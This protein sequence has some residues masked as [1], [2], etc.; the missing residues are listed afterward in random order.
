M[1][2]RPISRAV[3]SQA[4]QIEFAGLS[5]DWNPMHMDPVAARRTPAG[6][7]VVHGMHTVLRAVDD[8]A[9][10]SP[11]LSLPSTLT[12]RFPAPVYLNEVVEVL[13]VEHT[14]NSVR[15]Q[16]QVDGTAMV[17]LRMTLSHA[18]GSHEVSDPHTVDAAAVCRDLQLAE[19]ARRSGT[20]DLAS[21]PD[22][23]SRHFGNA[24]RWLGVDRVG[25][26]LCL[27]RLIGMECPGLHSLFSGFKIDFPLT[28]TPP[29][30]HYQVASIKDQL[31]L[32]KI[33]V[34]GFGICGTAEAFARQPPVVQPT[35]SEIMA[36]VNPTEFDLQRALIVGGSRGLGELTAKILAAGGGYPTITYAVGK[37]E[38]ER[39]V[40]EI[41]LAGGSC[42]ALHYDARLPPSLQLEQLSA[43]VS[44]LYYYATP[45]IQRRRTKR[46]DS[47]M[48]D[49][50]LE[51][52]VRG[53]YE[54]CVALREKSPERIAAFYPSSIAV[55]DRPREM[56]EYAMAKAAAEV[57]CADLN[58]SWPRVHI[59]SVRLPRVLTDQTAT[60]VPVESANALD[61]ILPIIRKVQAIEF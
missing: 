30:L 52:Y 19:M 13:E 49:D 27:S 9:A 14:N 31:R 12:V 33:E 24:V 20:I 55:E 44:R 34:R 47:A 39:V 61:V 3:F 37:D 8:F 1:T 5:G 25:G 23:I 18:R 60:V 53:F 51:F 21:E 22:R 10:S 54:L 6:R 45:Q 32:L 56:T 48:L 50:F 26:M 40:T 7:Q 29:V 42:N 16:A 38:A 43:P 59:L 4:T 58:R 15:L 2:P 35:T 57:L 46:F 36:A 41:R 11:N 28:G 17:D